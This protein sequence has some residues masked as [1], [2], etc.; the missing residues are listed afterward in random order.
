MTWRREPAS[1]RVIRHA[2]VL[3]AALAVLACAGGAAWGEDKTL[4]PLELQ[5]ARAEGLKKRAARVFYTKK[6][7][8]S[9][10]PEYTSSATMS[11]PPVF[12]FT[13]STKAGGKLCSIPKRIPIFF[14]TRDGRLR[15]LC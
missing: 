13:R 14:M 4:D 12:W 11:L 7:D 9:D 5:K 10:L 2:A 6:F 3:A 8:L 15:R 1:R